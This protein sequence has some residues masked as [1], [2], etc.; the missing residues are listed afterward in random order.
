[1]N[2]SVFI[3]ICMSIL[4]II[5]F[6]VLT[7]EAPT[8]AY[9]DLKSQFE[10]YLD[11]DLSSDDQLIKYMNTLNFDHSL[12][13]V[14]I[15]YETGDET[16]H[17]SGIIIDMSGI[18]VYVL[19]QYFELEDEDDL[20]YVIDYKNHSNTGQ[21][22]ASS[23]QY[24]VMLLKFTSFNVSDLSS[25]VMTDVMPLSG[26]I[27][28]SI[29]SLDLAF[30]QPLLGCFGSSDDDIYYDMEMIENIGVLGSSVYDIN[31]RLVG[32]RVYHDNEIV[33]IAIDVLKDFISENT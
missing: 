23:E 8:K 2:K 27:V 28:S 25:V 13:N 1:M 22:V 29:S 31:H 6:S 30:H 9:I 12:E 15:T 33:V 7:Y 3:L 20:I 14:A 26:E 11:H 17:Q 5:I 10:T 32:M 21:I 24:P 18:N 16:W 19:T 4:G